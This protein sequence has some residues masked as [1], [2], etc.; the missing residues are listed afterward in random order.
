MQST[1]WEIPDWMKQVRI[2]TVGRNI[3]N[4]TITE[5]EEELKFLIRVRVESE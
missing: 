2:K 5:T 4:L 1:S 3:N